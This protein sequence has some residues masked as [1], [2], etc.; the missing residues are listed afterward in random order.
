[1][2]REK[3]LIP[4]LLSG[5]LLAGCNGNSNSS[6]DDTTSNSGN[7]GGSVTTPDTTDT[8]NT[9][10]WQPCTLPSAIPTNEIQGT[11]EC[12]QAPVPLNWEDSASQQIQNTVIRVRSTNPAKGQ[13][14]LLDGGPGGAGY[15]YLQQLSLFDSNNWDVYIPIHRGTAGPDALTCSQS[16]VQFEQDESEFDESAMLRACF[17]ELQQQYG[18]NL[19]YFNAYGAAKDLGHTIAQTSQTSDKVIVFG[20]S[21]GTYW[22]QR[23]LQ[24]YPDQ[25]DAVILD[26]VLDL[27]SDVHREV[28]RHDDVG[29]SLLSLCDENSRCSSELGKPAAEL[30]QEIYARTGNEQCSILATEEGVDSVKDTLNSFLPEGLNILIPV[31]IKQL[32]RCEA[33]DIA[34][35]NNLIQGQFDAEGEEF[36]EEGSENTGR[37]ANRSSVVAIDLS[38][39]QDFNDLLSNNVIYSEIFRPTQSIGEIAEEASNLLFGSQSAAIDR[40]LVQESWPV[41]KSPVNTDLG[42][43]NLPVLIL[44]GALDPQTVPIWADWTK[45][46]LP[47][48]YQHLVLFPYAKHGVI[49]DSAL[50]DGSSCGVKIMHQFMDNPNADLDTSCVAQTIKPDFGFERAESQELS[51]QMFGTSDPWNLPAANSIF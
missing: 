8:T 49:E 40:F 26:G 22:A 36:E 28:I 38:S 21:Y 42:N 19:Q 29:R 10:T 14:W 16:E 5:L 50:S 51:Q 7:S 32:D 35:L 46:K 34:V 48:T 24:F 33:G 11:I 12:S 25:A 2:N 27:D 20:S 18:S 6:S 45:A 30:L 17:T 43:I 44:Q 9:I 3:Y 23:Y 47:G 4:A 39:A 15:S 37:Q 1:M 13:I 31:L 41:G